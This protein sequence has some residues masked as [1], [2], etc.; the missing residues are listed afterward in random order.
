LAV[1]NGSLIQAG[2]S[3]IFAICL[4]KHGYCVGRDW[5][6]SGPVELKV[7]FAAMVVDAA[8]T[9]SDMVN[10]LHLPEVG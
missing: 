6:R 10:E 3:V 2:I 7:A 4:T 9:A 1:G 5:Q 8:R